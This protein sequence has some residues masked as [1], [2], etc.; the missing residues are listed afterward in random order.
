MDDTTSQTSRGTNYTSRAIGLLDSIR[1]STNQK[2]NQEFLA[3]LAAF[4]RKEFERN[5]ILTH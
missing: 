2:V 3:V 4:K 1:Q 5:N